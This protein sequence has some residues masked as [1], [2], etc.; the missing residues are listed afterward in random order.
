MSF[1][2]RRSNRIP[3]KVPVEIA[4]ADA[5]GQPRLERTHTLNVDRHGARIISRSQHPVG[6]MINLGVPQ[7]GR[8]AH[9][10]V[11]W[12]SAPVAGVFEVGLQME[13]SVNIWGLHDEP[14]AVPAM[15]AGY[16][17]AFAMLVQILQEKGVL[18]PGELE[19]RLRGAGAAESP[20]KGYDFVVT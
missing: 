13:D 20:S 17:G 11:V 10:R 8:S 6:S 2:G 9:C 4:F 12:C 14:G 16:L 7:M 3:V 19:S 18:R 5:H 1:D 15:A